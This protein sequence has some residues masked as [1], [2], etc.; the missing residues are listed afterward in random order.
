MFGI[1]VVKTVG[2]ESKP[3]GQSFSLLFAFF[4]ALSISSSSAIG[5]H[6]QS[7]NGDVRAMQSRSILFS[8]IGEEDGLSQSA[9]NAIVQD[10][11]GY[12][13]FGTQEGLNRYDGSELRIYDHE[14]DNPNSLS[15]GWIWSLTIGSDG[16]LWIGTQGGGLNRYNADTDDFTTFRHEDGNANSLSSDRV[17]VVFEDNQNMLWMGTDGGGLNRFDPNTGLFQRYRHDPAD[18]SSITSDTVLAIMEDNDGRLWIGTKGGGL[19]YLDRNSGLFTHFRH[20]PE[21][22]GSLSDDQVRSIFEDRE[23]RIWVGTYEGGLNLFEPT[24]GE[25]RHFNHEPDNANSLSH[26]RVRSI[27]QD[28]AGT[29]WVG[30]DGG[31]NEWRAA[32]QG[33]AHY[34]NNPLDSSSISDN[35]ITQMFQDRGGVLWIGTNNGVNSWNYL[36]DAYTYYQTTGS[37]TQL[38][39]NLVMSIGESRNND[40]WIGTYGGGLNQVN[41]LDGTVKV[42][43]SA[44]KS[45]AQDGTAILRDDRVMAVYV[46]NNQD[47]WAGSRNGGLMHLNPETGNYQHF[48]HEPGYEG[49]ISSN[50]VTSIL[51]D[52]E[53][54]IWVGTHGGGL[55]VFNA[56]T[57]L[58]E[59]FRH[60]PANPK[61][62]SSDRVVALHRDRAGVLWVGTEDNGF[63]RYNEGSRDFE[64]FNHNPDDSESLS[65]DSAWILHEGYDGSLWIGTNGGGLNRWRPEDR[66]AGRVAF[67]KY[68]RGNGLL[69][70]TVQNLVE[71]SAGL[72]WITGNRGLVQLNPNDDSIRQFA[73]GS[74]LRS[75]EFNHGAGMRSYNGRLLLGSGS[76]MVAFY[77]SQITTNQHAPDIVLAAHGRTGPFDDRYRSPK[78]GDLLELDYREDLITFEF[79]GLD[80][81]APTMNQYR[82]KLE[83]FD[84]T[85]S[86]PDN[87]G[88]ATYTSLPPGEYTFHVQAANNDGVWN[89][90]GATLRFT[91]IPPIWLSPAAY[92][93]YILA[94]CA[95]IFG[96]TQ[97]KSRELARVSAHREEL[98]REVQERTQELAVRNDTLLTLNDQLKES[99]WTDSLTGLKN[100]RFLDEF[101]DTEVALAL[102]QARELENKEFPGSSPDI[103]PA[104]SFMMV[105]LDGFKA[106]NDS[107]GHH[108]GDQALLQV[109]DVLQSCTRASDTIFRWGGDEFLIVSRNTSSRAA[110]KL[111]DRIR[112]GL[113]EYGFRLGG[114]AIARLSGSIGFAVYPFSPL[115]PELATWQQV[116]AIADQCTYIA[117][118]NGKNC[119][120]S[121]HGTLS[122]TRD[123]VEVMSKDISALLGTGRITLRA[124]K[125]EILKV[126]NSQPKESS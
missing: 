14:F 15:D 56:R 106:I 90:E 67:S 84:R 47:V 52:T 116:S 44:A 58:F 111:A 57:H 64:R 93:A 119:W 23:G 91:I 126:A 32:E 28:K 20:N 3:Y 39:S 125:T 25:F 62:L 85:W 36:S 69:S 100:R 49:S 83:G 40:I 76:G 2:S 122:T 92:V 120:V 26:N 97:V 60:D 118:E 103:A 114:G 99:A 73:R 89:E 29:L 22:P 27:F 30:T 45:D 50:S 61:S 42:Y 24:T 37:R 70:D 48:V 94:I 11:K 13:W 79:S 105:D 21:V 123:D 35:R 110:E 68:H 104:L 113:S 109:R 80:Y 95:I 88:R 107:Y 112:I 98:E 59:T 124:S 108:A 33:F 82:Y 54:N 75:V 53:G 71:D 115:N 43:R 87:F 65:R 17:R 4:L 18:Y 7:G 10:D 46:D 38:S 77:P 19:S 74:G 121:V 1:S 117:K 34:L 78:N 16:T 5:M 86:T 8:R 6:T 12:V 102:R 41:E 101:I 31:L 81:T 9:I 66:A 55:N 96:Y 63:N 51:S 72:L